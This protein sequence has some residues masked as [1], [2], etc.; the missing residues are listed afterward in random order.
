MSFSKPEL[1]TFLTW[2]GMLFFQISLQAQD[3]PGP[4]HMVDT[5]DTPI[6]IFE[7][8]DP[9]EVT[10]ILDIKKYQ[11]EKF[12][13]EYMPAEF[14]YHLNDTTT[15]THELKIRA[16]GNFRRKHCSFAP[17]WLNIRNAGV[18]DPQLQNVNRIKVVTHCNGGRSY[19]DYVLKEY[20]VYRIYNLLSP[21]SFRVRLAKMRYVDTGRKNRVTENWAFMIEPEEMLAERLDAVVIKRD[22]LSMRHLVAKD[23]DLMAQFMY[24]IGNPDYSVYGRHNVKILGVGNYGGSGYTP[25]PY[26]FDYSGLVNAYY[27][28]PGEELGIESV[29]ERYYLGAC[30]SDQAYQRAINDLAGHREEILNLVQEF[31]LIEDKVRKE[32]VTYLEGYFKEAESG[33]FIKYSLR[34]TCR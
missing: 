34:S 28:I 25:V 12:K 33:N 15:I 17:F 29:R 20:L 10:L 23:M 11:R 16:R 4:D 6:D 14:Q 5:I 2:V 31:P 26:D 30:R 7:G 27:A 8:E 1:T 32:M 19:A 22:D 13:G 24:M 9:L 21:V 18:A 3:I